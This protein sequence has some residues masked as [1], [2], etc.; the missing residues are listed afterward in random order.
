[1][2]SLG[3]VGNARANTTGNAIASGMNLNLPSAA[4]PKDSNWNKLKYYEQAEKDSA[5][6]K[7]K[8]KSDRL[9]F[10][11]DEEEEAESMEGVSDAELAERMYGAGQLNNKNRSTS[12]ADQVYDRLSRI[13]K[14]IS[15]ESL[16]RREAESSPSPSSNPEIEN[17]SGMMSQM[18][19]GEDPELGQLDQML[20]KIIAIQNPQKLQDEHDEKMKASRGQVFAVQADSSNLNISTLG[21]E[22]GIIKPKV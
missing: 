11:L 20:D 10:G 13:Q 21:P 12:S 15:R 3:I 8:L 1:M 18:Q 2:W 16:P 4:A 14:E 9:L 17:L 7:S 22:Q 19:G 6:L 5:K